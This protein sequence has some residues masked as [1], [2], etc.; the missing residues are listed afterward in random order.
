LI[1]E[2]KRGMYRMIRKKL[3]EAE[4]PLTSIE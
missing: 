2:L 1:E 3:M 4:R